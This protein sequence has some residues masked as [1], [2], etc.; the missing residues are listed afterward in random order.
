METMRRVFLIL[1][2]LI[3][4]FQLAWAGA[5]AYCQHEPSIHGSWHF[6]HHEHQHKDGVK[7]E[8]EKKPI[9]DADCTICHV[10]SVPFACFEVPETRA[11]QRVELAPNPLELRFTSFF[12][13]APDRPQ[14]HRLA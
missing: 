1:F 8:T 6:G 5:A 13:R 12:A 7:S 2:V 4:P 10:A 14:W 9:V 11:A 3:L